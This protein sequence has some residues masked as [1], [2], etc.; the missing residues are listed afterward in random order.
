MVK[1]VPVV[2]DAITEEDVA[3]VTDFYENAC[4]VEWCEFDQELLFY[5]AA[6]SRLNGAA[7]I[8]GLTGMGIAIR[9][10]CTCPPETVDVDGT[11]M[12][13]KWSQVCQACKG[14]P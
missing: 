11:I 5:V 14:Y 6:R 1:H 3:I 13:I 2:V 10:R 7:V 8:S 9:Q 12:P 4:H